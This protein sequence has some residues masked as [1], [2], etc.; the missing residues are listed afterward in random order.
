MAATILRAASQQ[1]SPRGQPDTVSA[2]WQFVNKTSVGPAVLVVEDTKL[3]RGLSVLHITLY[4]N[5]LLAQ[6]PWV[7][8]QSTKAATAYIT[9]GN[10]DREQGVTL[11]T[12]W[13]LGPTPPPSVDLAKLPRGED[14]NWKEWIHYLRPHVQSLQNVDLYM[15]RAGHPLAATHDVWTR[16]ASGDLWVQDDL[17]F[18]L[19]I[20]PPLIVESFRPPEG[21]D[22]IPEGG[23]ARST[24][25]W[26]PTIVASLEIKKRLPAEGTR[27]LRFRVVCKTIKNGRY[28]AEVL[29]YDVE[30]DLVAQS[31]HVAMAVGIERNRKSH[32]DG[33]GKL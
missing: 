4:Q 2:H 31:H 16:L 3:G 32:P 15:P 7:T 30:G 10:M 21:S 26:Y 12:G 8:P 1:L 29:I 20:G 5:H 18:I 17:G 6:H 23:Y 14:A 25:M 11:P 24:S 28:D 22:E 33:K 19:D 13:T 9:N 27:W